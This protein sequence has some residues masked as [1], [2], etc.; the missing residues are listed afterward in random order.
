MVCSEAVGWAHLDV[1][2]VPAVRGVRPGRETPEQLY[3]LVKGNGT[4]PLA[5]ECIFAHRKNEI[6]ACRWDLMG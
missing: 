5:A 4:A 3:R 2:G 1:F 6:T